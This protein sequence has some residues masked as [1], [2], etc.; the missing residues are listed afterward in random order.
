VRRCGMRVL[1]AGLALLGAACSPE[2]DWREIRS[3]QGGFVALLPGK[4]KLEERE[5]SGSGGAV[6]HLWSARAGGAVYGV[7]YVDTP[8]AGPALVVRTRDALAAN[9]AGRVVADKEINQGAVQ[10]RE[11]RV[12]GTG[13]TLVGRVLARDRRLYQLVVVRSKGDIDAAG[14]E[15]F[16]SSFVVAHPT[17]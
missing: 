8:D 2:L 9:I 3:E 7:S 13:A 5:L 12:V 6:M 1:L 11:F 17:P 10:G 15:L 4:P 16:F 14:V